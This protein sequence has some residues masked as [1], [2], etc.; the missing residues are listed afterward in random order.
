MRRTGNR[1]AFWA[2]VVGGVS[3][4]QVVAISHFAKRV[5]KKNKTKLHV[6]ALQRLPGVL[7]GPGAL[8]LLQF[9]GKCGVK[10]T[11]VK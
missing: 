9:A 2:K 4:Q 11:E 1:L 10:E 7:L 3:T 6:V 8:A 5:N